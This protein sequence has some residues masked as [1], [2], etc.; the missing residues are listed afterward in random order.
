MLHGQHLSTIQEFG[1]TQKYTYKTY[2]LKTKS[3]TVRR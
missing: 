3:S 1:T 2:F